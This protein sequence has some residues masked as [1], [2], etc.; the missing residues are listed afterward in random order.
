MSEPKEKN[1]EDRSRVSGLGQKVLG[2]IE[3]LAG[4]VNADP[5]AQEEGEFNIEVGELRDDLEDA[6]GRT[7]GREEK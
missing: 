3:K 6:S 1:K 4:I 2:E 7:S 5:L